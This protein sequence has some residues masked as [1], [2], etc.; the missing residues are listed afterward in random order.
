MIRR[1]ALPLGFLLA[2][3]ASAQTP[4]TGAFDHV[5]DI[6]Q[7]ALPG[8]TA[9]DA[10]TQTYTITGAGVNMWARRDEFQFAW[11]R[12]SGD[13]ILTAE[14]AFEPAEQRREQHR[15]HDRPE[16]RQ[17]KAAQRPREG[18]RHQDDEG[19]ERAILERLDGSRGEWAGGISQCT[20]SGFTSRWKQK[21]PR[22]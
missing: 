6:G 19:E 9:Y 15:Q 16:H 21:C 22:P 20:V 14:A 3:A 5:G 8:A 18:D 4:M 11:T 10:A 1:F 17:Q 13:F 2:A 7:P 12:L